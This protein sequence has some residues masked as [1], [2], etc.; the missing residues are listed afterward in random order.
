VPSREDLLVQH[1][2][3]MML[4]PHLLLNLPH[5]AGDGEKAPIHVQ[6]DHIFVNGAAATTLQGNG[7]GSAHGAMAHGGSGTGGGG[8]GGGSAGGSGS[9]ELL[10]YSMC[11]RYR[12]AYVTTVLYKPRYAADAGTPGLPRRG[13]NRLQASSERR[14]G[15]GARRSI[16]Y[17][18]AQIPKTTIKRDDKAARDYIAYDVEAVIVVRGA[19]MTLRSER[20]Y[21]HFRLLDQ[22][23]RREFGSRGVYTAA[24]LLP[25][26]RTFG[27]LDTGFVAERRLGLE[28]Y[29]QACIECEHVSISVA[30]SQFIDSGGG[31]SEAGGGCEPS[32]SAAQ[33][34]ARPE[35][36][37]L[38]ERISTRQGYLL[39]QSSRRVSWR[40]R[41]F[42]LYDTELLYYYCEGVCDPFQPLNIVHVAGAAV[43]RIALVR[44]QLPREPCRCCRRAL[45]CRPRGEW[46]AGLWPD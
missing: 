36:H 44:A 21:T 6:L 3:S 9:D 25:P 13:G 26:K 43:R 41:Y 8:A 12:D 22:M 10:I 14:D 35:S 16:R 20:R 18:S 17:L 38:L 46:L 29:L 24:R 27:N 40:S 32:S 23:L 45:H 42:C 39:K 19:Q 15:G 1:A 5:L 37:A 34:L 30:F 2:A 28:R 31:M 33:L 11:T 7:A 4:P